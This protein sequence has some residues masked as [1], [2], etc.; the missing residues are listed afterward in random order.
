MPDFL[1]RDAS[2]IGALLIVASVVL[3]VVTDV[4]RRKIYNILTFPAMALGF[5]VNGVLDGASGILFAGAGLFLGAALFALPVA[6]LGRGAG[7][8]KL[9]AAVGALGGPTFVL[10]CALLTGIAGGVFAVVVLLSKRRLG[11]VMAGMALDAMAGQ[12]PVAT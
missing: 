3:A 11:V 8:L 4:R 1:T 9:L 2:S 5:L 12:V 7:D 10:W 6:F